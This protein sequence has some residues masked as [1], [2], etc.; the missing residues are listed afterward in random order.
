MINRRFRGY[1]SHFEFSSPL[2]Q[3]ELCTFTFK[4]VNSV[5]RGKKTKELTASPSKKLSCLDSE[6][7]S[8]TSYF[9]EQKGSVGHFFYF[10]IFAQ[11]LIHSPIH[12]YTAHSEALKANIFRIIV[13][14]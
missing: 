4:A 12:P 14:I 7:F 9:Y 1:G 8:Q 2:G 10:E 3:V 6:K 11:N 13:Q 5:N